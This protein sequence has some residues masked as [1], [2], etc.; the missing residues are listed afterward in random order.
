MRLLACGMRGRGVS[1]RWCL[2]IRKPI[3]N[4]RQILASLGF[5][6]SSL[7]GRRISGTFAVRTVIV[8]VSC[9]YFYDH[10]EGPTDTAVTLLVG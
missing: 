4:S 5:R 1:V 6:A 2:S 9:M 8:N 10:D 7:G 3:Q